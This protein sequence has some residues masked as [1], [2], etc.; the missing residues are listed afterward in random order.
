LV[1]AA[2]E[3]EHGN[4]SFCNLLSISADVLDRSST[5]AA[6]NSAEAL[7]AGEIVLNT[8]R[9][10]AVPL[11]SGTNDE[12]TGWPFFDAA[13]CD[14]QN[15]AG[16]AFVGDDEIAATAYDKE[17]QVIFQGERNGGLDIL[18][19]FCATEEARVAAHT[20]GSERGERDFFLNVHRAPERKSDCNVQ[21]RF[22]YLR[23]ADP[24][25]R[26]WI[27]KPIQWLGRDDKVMGNRSFEVRDYA[28]VN[29]SFI[30]SSREVRCGLF[31]T[32]V[33]P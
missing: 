6:G 26:D 16:P 11:F 27:G 17:K 12:Q 23:T 31:S 2:I 5:H 13:N 14:L 30:L 33:R 28:W 1:F 19:V 22:D 3:G 20:E 4:D 9:D 10:E 8:M 29:M 15:Q 7:D 18:R 21:G 32:G 24:S 25:A